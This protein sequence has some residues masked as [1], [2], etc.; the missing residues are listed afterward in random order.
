M[1]YDNNY[2]LWREIINVQLS[3]GFQFSL[4]EPLGIKAIFAEEQSREAIKKTA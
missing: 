2:G 4:F 1:S 3:L